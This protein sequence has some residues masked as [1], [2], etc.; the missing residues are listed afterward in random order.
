[1]RGPVTQTGGYLWQRDPQHSAGLRWRD[2]GARIDGQVD[3]VGTDDRPFYPELAVPAPP[4]AA[5]SFALR[6][7]AVADSLL[8]EL[9][10]E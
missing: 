4:I 7:R 1:V 6:K 3:S 10:R 8:K 2:G 9:A 5:R